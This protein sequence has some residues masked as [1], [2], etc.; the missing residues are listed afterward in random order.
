MATNR[1]P[2]GACIVL[3]NGFVGKFNPDLHEEVFS[4]Y[5]D[6]LAYVHE[7]QETYS[8]LEYYICPIMELHHTTVQKHRQ[9]Y[10]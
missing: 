10:M 3:V 7:Q 5:H 1:P 2:K 6:A 9:G 4:T 8:D